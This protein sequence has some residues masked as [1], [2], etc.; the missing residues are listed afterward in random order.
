MSFAQKPLL[1]SIFLLVS[2]F[3][4]PAAFADKSAKLVST[5]TPT[6]RLFDIE[7]LGNV[8]YA[9]GEAGLIMKTTDGGETWE[10]EQSNT[11]LAL[12]NISLTS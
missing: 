10:K 8:G 5:Q 3:G 4:I 12:T 9:V 7:M 6:D 11:T 1:T 2:C